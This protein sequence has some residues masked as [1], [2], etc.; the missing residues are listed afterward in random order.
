MNKM[1][2]ALMLGVQENIH[3]LSAMLDVTPKARI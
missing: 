2:R 3:F 1:S